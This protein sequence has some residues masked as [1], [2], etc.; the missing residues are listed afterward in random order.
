MED[1]DRLT[2]PIESEKADRQASLRGYE[3]LTYPADYP[4]EILVDKWRKKAI[5]IPPGQRKF[6]WSQVQSSKLIESFLMG[7]P[8]P[9]IYFYQDR[10][11]NSLLVVDGKQRLLS[12]VFFFSGSFGYEREGQKVTHFNLVGLNEQSPFFNKTYEWLK[13]NDEQAFN[14]FNNSVLRSFVIK[15]LMPEDDTSIFE[16]FE[17]LNSGG[18]ILQPQEI[19]N[20]LCSGSFNE[21]LKDL[22]KHKAWRQILGKKGEDKRMRD[23]EL[24]LRFFA[25]FYNHRHYEKPMKGFLNKYMKTNRRM[26]EEKKKQFGD[27]FRQTADTIVRFLGQKPFNIHRG[28]NAAVYDSVF[29]AFARHVNELKRIDITQD[30]IGDKTSRY[31]KLISDEEYTS[32]I[33]S[34]TTDKDIVPKRISKAEDMLF[35]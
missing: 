30:E 14:K 15:Q 5:L 11:D 2:Q 31:R 3:I 27:L 28:L 34:A 17:R 23:I 19:R 33:V 1:E 21:L 24:I 32:W 7:L 13:E 25:P 8:V 4:L 18:V 26:S 9:P 20:C 6:V 10:K 35:G 22:N 16:V 12:I 29:T